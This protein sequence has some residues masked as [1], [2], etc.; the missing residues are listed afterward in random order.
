MVTIELVNGVLTT[1]TVTSSI[2]GFD[3]GGG[4]KTK[5][6]ITGSTQS[7]IRF[8]FSPEK[9]LRMLKFR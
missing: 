2:Y 8:D 6:L 7:R 9:A 3:G 1:P 5:Q 4:S